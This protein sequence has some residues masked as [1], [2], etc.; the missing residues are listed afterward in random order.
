MSD[1]HISMLSLMGS[2]FQILSF[3]FIHLTSLG[4]EK[5]IKVAINVRLST[6]FNMLLYMKNYIYLSFSI[7]LFNSSISVCSFLPVFFNPSLLQAPLVRSYAPKLL[8]FWSWGKKSLLPASPVLP[9]KTNWACSFQSA[10]TC[11]SAATR[12]SISGL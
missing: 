1:W 8:N 11:H 5:P 3:A 9:P 6:L 10:G 7:S 12:S 4:I 2:Y